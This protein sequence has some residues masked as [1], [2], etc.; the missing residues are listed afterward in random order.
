MSGEVVHVSAYMDAYTSV[1][2]SYAGTMKE[3]NFDP[4]G[5][6]MRLFA[7]LESYLGEKATAIYEKARDL[8]DDSLLKFYDEHY[9]GWTKATKK[10]AR[11]FRAF[12][13]KWFERQFNN[14]AE[15]VVE[16]VVVC[17]IADLHMKLWT[18]IV[19]QPME[20]RLARCGRESSFENKQ[21]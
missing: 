21:Q 12:E 1:C 19:H 5:K 9:E 20:E 7:R 18:S 6:G 4:R 13:E 11:L 8:P 15:A 16:G 14:N 2:Q 3:L 10:N 17:R